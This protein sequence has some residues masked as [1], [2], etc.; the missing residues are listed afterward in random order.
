MAN[1]IVFIEPTRHLVQLLAHCAEV[2][3][4]ELG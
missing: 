2:E 1:L 4:L 3:I